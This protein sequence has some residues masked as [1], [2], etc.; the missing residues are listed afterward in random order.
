VIYHVEGAWGA[1]DF[2]NLLNQIH[3]L[4][5]ET[6]GIVDVIGV[7][8]NAA[9]PAGDLLKPNEP[10]PQKHPRT[11]VF[12][13]VG[14]NRFIQQPVM[15]TFRKMYAQGYRESATATG[16]DGAKGLIARRQRER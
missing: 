7:Y 2:Y 3:S 12:V 14:M 6:T 11:G 9:I 8:Q 1:N 4:T 13:M 15:D 5:E 10:V 16:L